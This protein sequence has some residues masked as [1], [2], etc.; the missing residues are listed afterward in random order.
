MGAGG[1]D[2]ED[3]R[4][5]PWLKPLLRERF[6]VQCP[7]HVDSHRSECNMYCLDCMDGSLCSLCLADHKDHHAIQVFTTVYV[8]I[9]SSIFLAVFIT[10]MFVSHCF[11]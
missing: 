10:K 11:H 7:L 4:W 5:P 1:P 3:N 9:H 6:F 8:S 2:D